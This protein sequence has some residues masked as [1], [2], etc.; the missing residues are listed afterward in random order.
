MK[1]NTISFLY[2]DFFQEGGKD[3]LYQKDGISLAAY[4]LGVYLSVE[5]FSNSEANEI[6]ADD[7]L[8]SSPELA[9]LNFYLDER[10]KSF[11]YCENSLIS[12]L[13]DGCRFEGAM[14]V[15]YGRRDD[16]EEDLKYFIATVKKQD[17]YYVF[18]LVSTH[19]MSSYLWD[20]FEDILKSIQ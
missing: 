12:V 11:L 3:H 13:P 16:Y 7:S 5:S 1:F 8:N 17:V 10:R 19:E 20:D 9:V 15:L 4:D 2:P 18:Q 6:I 14:E